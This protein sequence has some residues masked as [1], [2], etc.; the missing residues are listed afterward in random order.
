MERAI[1]LMIAR[2]TANRDYRGNRLPYLNELKWV[3]NNT[4]GKKSAPLLLKK[5]VS[6]SVSNNKWF[7][8]N[9]W[10]LFE[11][12]ESSVQLQIQGAEG[13]SY[14]TRLCYDSGEGLKRNCLCETCI[15][16]VFSIRNKENGKIIPEDLIRDDGIGS[17]CISQ[18][19]PHLEADV[20]VLIK[21]VKEIS[22]KNNL[23]KKMKESPWN[24]CKRN[25]PWK[26]RKE[27]KD[28]VCFYCQDKIVR[29]ICKKKN[30]R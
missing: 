21:R 14:Q 7:A 13:E 30:E 22:K 24:Y 5:L 25:T 10:E 26:C 28:G 19:L 29:K 6:Y 27:L 1:S 16:Y 12:G 20:S 9:E 23:I 18:F 2:E 17:T 8:I 3:F 11:E 15:R 4:F